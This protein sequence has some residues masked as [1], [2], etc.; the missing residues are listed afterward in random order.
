[1]GEQLRD[2]FTQRR[3]RERVFI[4]AIVAGLVMLE[5]EMRHVVRQRQEPGVVAVHARSEQ[6]PRLLHQ[7]AVAGGK[8]PGHR[9]RRGAVGDQREAVLQLGK[10]RRALQLDALRVAAHLQRRVDQARE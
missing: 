1:M 8:V 10:G 2:A 9:Q 7:A 5:P 4:H 6:R 3:F